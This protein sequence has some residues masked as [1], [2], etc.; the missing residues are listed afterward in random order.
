MEKVP[1][2]AEVLA[3]SKRVD[4]NLADPDHK[5][6]LPE[7]QPKSNLFEGVDEDEFGGNENNRR[8]A[9]RLEKT[10]EVIAGNATDADLTKVVKQNLT[11]AEK[12]AE[13]LSSEK[14]QGEYETTKVNAPAWKP[15]S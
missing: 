2:F 1:T 8:V 7:P 12:E 15:N 4:A 10:R 13:K 3:H 11:E 5:E 14:G 9:K 6:T